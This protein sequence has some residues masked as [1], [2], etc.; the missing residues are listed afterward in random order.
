MKTIVIQTAWLGD[1]ILTTPLVELLAKNIGEKVDILT[2]PRW[3]DVWKNNPYVNEVLHFD[4]YGIDKGISGINQVAKKLIRNR[5][6]IAFLAQKHWR[7]AILAYAARIPERIGFENSPA[8]MLYTK[9]VPFKKNEHEIRRLLTLA[10]PLGINAQ[11]IA[12]KMYPA[13]TEREKAEEILE[14][15][16]WRGERIIVLAPQSSWETKQYP[17]FSELV[18]PL[19]KMGYFLVALG[20]G[21]MAQK[22]KILNHTSG[23]YVWDEPILVSAAVMERASVVIANDSGSGHIASAVGVPTITIFGP[24]VPEQGFSPWGEKNL[25]IQIPLDC[26][27]CGPHGHKKCPQKHHNCMRLIKP[28]NVIGAVIE[29]LR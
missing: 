11:P 15:G 20:A 8:K 27:P 28:E 26:R 2:L 9:V 25:A 3:N 6:D 13:D 1:N 12:P 19:A 14:K 4:K 5:Y 22:D 7:S 10:E 17:H 24:T 29:M 16:G 23:I 18:E 21:K